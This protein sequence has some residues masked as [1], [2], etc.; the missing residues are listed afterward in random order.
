MDKSKAK[1]RTPKYNIENENE[2]E[3]KNVNDLLGGAKAKRGKKKSVADDFADIAV[4]TS[5]I[6]EQ[7]QQKKTAK[8]VTNKPIAKKE[9]VIEKSEE[10]EQVYTKNGYV[11][12]AVTMTDQL[13]KEQI[14]EKLED[15]KKVD[16]IF[17]VPLGVHLR[18]F[19]NINGKMVFRMGGLLHKNTGLPDYV[20]LSTSP[21]G[22][23]GWSVQV[24]DTLFYRKMTLQEIKIEYQAII[25]ELITKNKKL[26]DDNKK[27]NE[28][29]EKYTR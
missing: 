10:E 3:N 15:Y 9:K 21:T 19:S 6:T 12:P 23:P 8:I 26:K 20:I 17:K 13:S 5:S 4:P 29:L 22:K 16:D 24:K 28:K 18:Y 25:D 27:L 2:N 14:E 1:S 7:S 11:R